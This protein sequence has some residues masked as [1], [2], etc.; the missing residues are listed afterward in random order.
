MAEL[1]QI[2]PTC[3]CIHKETRVTL[4]G[5]GFLDV[6]NVRIRFKTPQ[7]DYY[8][9]PEF[10]T[11]SSIILSTPALHFPTVAK[12]EVSFFFSFFGDWNQFHS[13]LNLA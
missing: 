6:G 5:C 13:H 12:V 10:A 11:N 4:R 3:G 7:K 8:V 1:I 2:S 9:Q